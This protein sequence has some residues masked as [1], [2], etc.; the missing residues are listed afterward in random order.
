MSTAKFR[1]PELFDS[2][3]WAVFNLFW[4]SAPKLMSQFQPSTVFRGSALQQLDNVYAWA[5][6]T[7]AAIA[8]LEMPTVR[9]ELLEELVVIKERAAGIKSTVTPEHVLASKLVA[10]MDRLVQDDFGK[11]AFSELMLDLMYFE[12]YDKLIT[13]GGI[14]LREFVTEVDEMLNRWDWAQCGQYKDAQIMSA[15]LDVRLT[16]RG[17]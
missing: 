4:D 1:R 8:K 17:E 11:G 2:H 16:L 3:A 15:E 12:E 5:T 14:G 6:S 10:E 9:E 7:E 13:Y